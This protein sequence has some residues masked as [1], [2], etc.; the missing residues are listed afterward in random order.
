[1]GAR[2]LILCA[3]LAAAA[4][5]CSGKS[6]YLVSPALGALPDPR[7]AVLP[8]D[9][10]STD[11]NAADIMRK[12]AAEGFARKGYPYLPLAEVDARLSGM[13]ISEGGQ[14]PGL[15]PKAI[16]A[17]LGADLLCYG[18]VE[19]FTFQ[20][21][22]FV[23]RKEVRLHLKVISASTGETLYEKS[24]TGKDFQVYTNKDDAKRALVEQLAVK[25]VQN[26][27]K[28]PLKREAEIS[29]EKALDSLPRR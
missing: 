4:W 18:D 3:V 6:A 19:K 12:L 2:R 25:M 14:L 20:D 1:M 13:G 5:G 29:A 28:T 22:G 23:V 26:I 15:A 16:G 9:D 17:A 10:Q 7:V 11:V 27:L 8:F 24:G 21:L